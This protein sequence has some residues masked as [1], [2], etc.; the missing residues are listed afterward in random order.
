MPTSVN[1]LNPAYSKVL[2]IVLQKDNGDEAF[3][4][5]KPNTLCRFEKIE[6]LESIFEL[7]PSG[8]LVVKDTSDIISHIKR[9][10]IDTIVATFINGE[11]NKFSITSTSYITNAASETEENFVSINFSNHLYKL[12]QDNSLIKILNTPKP[13]V[14]KVSSLVSDI[15]SK[16]TSLFSEF[17]SATPPRLMVND[18]TSN[19]ALYKPLNPL[20]D[21]IEVANENF[22]Q[23]LY[24]LSSMACNKLTFEPNYLFWT[25]FENQLNFKYF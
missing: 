9:E 6:F 20:E 21:K 10:E 2:D 3:S 14:K 8:S 18:E 17:E 23:Y 7:F 1:Q 24:Y 15:V 25:G 4:I 13:I 19:Y 16:S 22:I 5:L 12:S 11:V